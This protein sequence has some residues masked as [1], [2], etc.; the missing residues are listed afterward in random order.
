M[1]YN[2]APMGLLRV[3]Y[4]QSPSKGPGLLGSLTDVRVPLQKACSFSGLSVCGA[5][6]ES[7]MAFL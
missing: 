2:R 3:M 6:W 7:P 5:V 4:G 1:R